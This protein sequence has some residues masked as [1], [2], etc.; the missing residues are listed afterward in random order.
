MEQ[1]VEHCAI[2]HADLQYDAY[3]EVNS[4]LLEYT[5]WL[6]YYVVT[7]KEYF[8]L[9]PFFLFSAKNNYLL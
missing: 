2:Q 6:S 8:L 3:G 7:S 9:T 5:K 4:I 1:T